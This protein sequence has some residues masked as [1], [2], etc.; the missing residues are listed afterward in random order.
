MKQILLMSILCA[1]SLITTPVVK[2]GFT[3]EKEDFLRL[4][5]KRLQTAHEGDKTLTLKNG[6]AF[7]V[8]KREY[9]AEPNFTCW[10]LNHMPNG[11]VESFLS[12]DGCYDFS[13]VVGGGE[14]QR[15]FIMKR[16]ENSRKTGVIFIRVM[17]F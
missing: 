5:V 10:E 7:K 16:L 9:C 17:R 3:N 8:E 4:S 15:L 1:T 12:Y 2:A 13:V 14:G 11:K 6:R